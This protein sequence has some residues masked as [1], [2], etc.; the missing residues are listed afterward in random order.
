MTDEERNSIPNTLNLSE[1]EI[2]DAWKKARNIE[3]NKSYIT[4]HFSVI[5]GIISL[6]ILL[7][8]KFL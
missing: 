5:L 8:M 6:G 1:K 2:N 4:V 3:K 7:L